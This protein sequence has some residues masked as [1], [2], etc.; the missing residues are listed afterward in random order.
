MTS[1]SVHW[2]NCDSQL[3]NEKFEL[4]LLPVL[5]GGEVGVFSSARSVYSVVLSFLSSFQGHTL[6]DLPNNPLY[7]GTPL[8]RISVLVISINQI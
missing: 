5:V 6:E 3:T 8:S 7:L 2:L 4:Y 1:I